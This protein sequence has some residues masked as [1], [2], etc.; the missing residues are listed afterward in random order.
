MDW[1]VFSEK[2]LVFACEMPKSDGFGTYFAAFL[3]IASSQNEWI[4]NIFISNVIKYTA[5]QELTQGAL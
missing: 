5:M 3:W 4:G 2:G 1:K